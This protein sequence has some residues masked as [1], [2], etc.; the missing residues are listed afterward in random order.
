MSIL[1]VKDTNVDSKLKRYTLFPIQ[2]P[3]VWKMYKKHLAAFW[4][5]E[6]IDLAK[7]VVDWDK[8]SNDEKHFI[9][10]VL[11]EMKTN[12]I[13]GMNVKLRVQMLSLLKLPSIQM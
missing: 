10:M 7:D 3:E 1:E 6:E 11:V 12:S 2:Y 9:S 5:A 4:T 8:L 13:L